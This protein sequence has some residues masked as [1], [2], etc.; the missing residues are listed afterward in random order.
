MDE[1]PPPPEK[2]IARIAESRQRW[3]DRRP[4]VEIMTTP[5]DDGS[6]LAGPPHNDGSGFTMRIAD[7]FGS[8][9]NDFIGRQLTALE[10]T[11]RLR[12][13]Q[14]SPELDSAGV[15]ASLAIVEAVRP[16]NEIEAALAVQMAQNHD[17]ATELMGMARHAESTEKLQIYANLAVKMQRTFTAQIEALARLRGKSQQTVRVE[18]VTVEA[19]GQ[20]IVGDIHQHGRA[21]PSTR[22]QEP[23]NAGEP[24]DSPTVRRSALRSPDALGATLPRSGDAKRPVPNARRAEPRRT[25]KSERAEARSLHQRDEGAA[26]PVQ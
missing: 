3:I 22:H 24:A 14:V 16:E 5:R 25:R 2:E 9:S 17:L 13:S 4:P 20:A 10:R 11:S 8:R 19:G 1:L 26:A 21:A 23:A 7:A 12:G 18:H 15:N 6:F